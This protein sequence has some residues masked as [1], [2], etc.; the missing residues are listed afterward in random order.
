VTFTEWVHPFSQGATAILVL[1]IV[2]RRYQSWRFERMLR[3][4]SPVVVVP[5]DER[6]ALQLPA[7]IEQ[8]DGGWRAACPALE[9]ASWVADTPDQAIGALHSLLEHRLHDSGPVPFVLVV[10]DAAPDAGWDCSLQ[11]DVCDAVGDADAEGA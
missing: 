4:L 9:G 7:T 1:Q 2:W 6:S 11:S 10:L 8:T 3:S 5:P